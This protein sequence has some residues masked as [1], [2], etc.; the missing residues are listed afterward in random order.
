MS[1]LKSGHG[2][3]TLYDYYEG[4]IKKGLDIG[5]DE[6]DKHIRFKTGQF[7]MINGLDNVGKTLFVVWYF[8]CL[9]MN[10]ECLQYLMHACFLLSRLKWLICPI[11]E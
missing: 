9:S 2:I 3:N 1:I 10:R 8:L 7:V 6:V 5:V 11:Y 4:R